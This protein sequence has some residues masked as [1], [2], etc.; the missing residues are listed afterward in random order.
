MIY[1][2]VGR[3]YKVRVA[4]K[5]HEANWDSALSL[6]ESLRRAQTP[7]RTEIRH[8]IE[9]S[10]ELLHPLNEPL[11]VESPLPEMFRNLREETYSDWLVWCLQQMPPSRVFRI[12]KIEELRD[13]MPDASALR[14]SREHRV[15]SGHPGHSGRLDIRLLIRDIP[16][17]DIEIKLDPADQADTVKQLG[18]AQSGA[19]YRILIAPSGTKESYD[20]NFRW[21]SWVDLCG[22]LR[23][24][25]RRL[26]AN[27]TDVSRLGLVL[28]FVAAAEQNLLNV[29]SATLQAIYYRNAPVLL[30]T[31]ARLKRF[32]HGFVWRR[33][34]AENTTD[35]MKKGLEK[36]YEARRAVIFFEQ[37]VQQ[38]ARTVLSQHLN[39]FSEVLKMRLSTNAIKDYDADWK[40]GPWV[41]VF[42]SCL[43]PLSKI[44]VGLTWEMKPDGTEQPLAAVAVESKRVPTA[45]T[46]FGLVRNVD[47]A[48]KFATSSWGYVVVIQNQLDSDEMPE[49]KNRLSAIL[50][51]WIRLLKLS[52]GITTLKPRASS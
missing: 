22:A 27:G 34:M 46:L 44:Y 26:L 12:L 40:T 1:N 21:L 52:G 32:G 13:T 23:R 11:L 15:P 2:K 5:I 16:T 25:T 50:M 38:I 42:V 7:Y 51:E 41:A 47:P 18:Y 36:Y 30:V 10:I 17:I 45:Q 19:P 43:D 31:D 29:P 4:A 24:E 14:Y 9:R 37:R 48:P 39:E 49:F 3:R 28:A 35:F 20:G 8:A 6:V 33:K